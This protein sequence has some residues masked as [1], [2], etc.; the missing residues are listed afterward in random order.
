MIMGPIPGGATQDTNKHFW[1]RS[2][3]KS[4]S[5]HGAPRSIGFARKTAA[6]AALFEAQV[7][8]MECKTHSSI[9]TDFLND[10]DCKRGQKIE[11]DHVLFIYFFAKSLGIFFIFEASENWNTYGLSSEVG[12]CM[13][14]VA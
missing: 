7:S 3:W 2:G 4:S 6:P 1:S 10:L 13:K 9:F 12:K 8:I 5:K 11:V 14:R